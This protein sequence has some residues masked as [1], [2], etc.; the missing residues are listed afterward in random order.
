ME[1]CDTC[2][3]LGVA[4]WE[5]CSSASGDNVGT[6]FDL[7]ISAA[8]ESTVQNRANS[9]EN[10][11]RRMLPRPRPSTLKLS[12][13][14]VTTNCDSAL[15]YSQHVYENPEEFDRIVNVSDTVKMKPKTNPLVSIK[16]QCSV[17]PNPALRNARDIL[18]L[19]NQTAAD[20]SLFSPQSTQSSCHQLKSPSST[21]HFPYS[22]TS[23]D[24]DKVPM[25]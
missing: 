17:S 22:P 19:R 1:T 18:C 16:R 20:Q 5:T 24:L 25:R 6:V 8:F 14:L 15:N 4:G 13:P 23:S 21:N 2:E 10:K 7:C 9:S 11:R 3:R 12:S